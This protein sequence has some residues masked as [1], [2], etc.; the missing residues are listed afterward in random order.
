VAAPLVG[1]GEGLLVGGPAL[2][3]KKLL[4]GEKQIV[5]DL[6]NQTIRRLV[7][8]KAISPP[9]FSLMPRSASA[10]VPIGF[11]GTLTWLPKSELPEP[12]EVTPA[13]PLAALKKL[14]EE[15]WWKDKGEPDA[16]G[17][18]AAQKKLWA[19]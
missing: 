12:R 10:P 19:R 16:E 4:S 9:D 6:A 5:I 15:T 1:R 11:K 13:P 18:I 14:A 2:G 17:R 3:G 8:E 7:W